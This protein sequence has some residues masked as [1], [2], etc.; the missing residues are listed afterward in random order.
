MERHHH[1][2][3]GGVLDF[4]LYA[5]VL[6]VVAGDKAFCE[7][8]TQAGKQ[9]GVR[10]KTA[11]SRFFPKRYLL[12]KINVEFSCFLRISLSW[13]CLPEHRSFDWASESR[14]CCCCLPAWNELCSVWVGGCSECVLYKHQA[15][16]MAI[17][18]KSVLL[19]AH[20]NAWLQS[21]WCGVKS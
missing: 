19:E 4:W 7:Y 21:A 18:N 11:F 14:C 9:G 6:V 13:K 15:N 16:A 10:T 17:E 20:G 5:R 3:T 2:Q 12:N 8:S 1:H